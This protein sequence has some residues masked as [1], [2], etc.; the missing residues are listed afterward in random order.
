MTEEYRAPSLIK[1]EL[2]D[3]AE[4]IRETSQLISLRPEDFV[5]QQTL[6]SL[7]NREDAIL[8]DLR[9]TYNRLQVDALDILIEGDAVR[10]FALYGG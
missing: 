6:H 8:N 10:G 5:L 4:L 7:K 3:L 1:E 2:S 9:E